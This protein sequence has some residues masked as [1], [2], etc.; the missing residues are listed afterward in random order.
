MKVILNKL[1]NTRIK[2]AII[3]LLLLFVILPIFK[4]NGKKINMISFVTNQLLKAHYSTEIESV[5]IE[6]PDYKDNEPG[7]W[8][9]DKTAEWLNRDTAEVTFDVSSKRKIGD[10]KKDIIFVFDISSSMYG[11]KFER[12]KSDVK[13]LH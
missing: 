8:H 3:C 11:K 6:S 1:S 9:I 5:E 4:Y 2:I 7:S 13:D 12:A 10:R